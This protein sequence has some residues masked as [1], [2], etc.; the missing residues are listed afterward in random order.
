MKSWESAA[1]TYSF[2]QHLALLE[3]TVTNKVRTDHLAT[4]PQWNLGG[5]LLKGHFHYVSF[6]RKSALRNDHGL[7]LY[8]YLEQFHASSCLNIVAG[9]VLYN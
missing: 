6:I 7:A 5:S 3:P 2:V 1:V 8:G 4:G 9:I